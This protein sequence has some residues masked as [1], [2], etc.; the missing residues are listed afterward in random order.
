MLSRWV[1]MGIGSYSLVWAYREERI[2]FARRHW[3]TQYLV[4][5]FTGAALLNFLGVLRI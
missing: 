4:F 5:G 1:V 3:L 2:E